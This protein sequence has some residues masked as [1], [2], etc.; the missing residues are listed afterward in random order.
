L[1]DAGAAPRGSLL[2]RPAPP[3]LPDAAPAPPVVAESGDPFSTLRVVQLVACV[4]RARPALV[5][6]LVDALNGR[7]LDWLFEPG[8][9]ID[10]LAALRATWLADFRTPAGVELEDGAYGPQLTL[11]DSVRLD[12]WIVRQAQR[13]TAECR[14]LLDEFSRRDRAGAGS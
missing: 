3:G 4:E 10:A 9:V 8:V 13:L 2:L 6:D 14:A 12:A 1:T 5:A 11:E 7:H